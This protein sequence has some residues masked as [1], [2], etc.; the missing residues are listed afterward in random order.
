M[1]GVTHDD[2][3]LAMIYDSFTYTVLVT[4]EELGFCGKGE[5]GDFVSGG[6]IAPG[7]EFP[8]NT[9][10]GGLAYTHTGMYGMFALI[11]GV[12]QLRR[13]F[14]APRQVPRYRACPRPRHRRAL[15][16]GRHSGAGARIRKSVV[17]SE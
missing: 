13:E 11:E 2:L 5:G 3:D 16:V 15:V 9:S 6:R 8:M 7:G 12:Q 10:G 4:L 14:E 1:A 17:C